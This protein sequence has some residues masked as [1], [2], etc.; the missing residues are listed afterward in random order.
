MMPL[1]V[2][3]SKGC[4]LSGQSK[5]YLESVLKKKGSSRKSQLVS[6]ALKKC[7]NLLKVNDKPYWF[8]SNE[9]FVAGYGQ[10]YQSTYLP[11][12]NWVYITK[13]SFSM[14]KN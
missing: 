1:L 11:T 7:E 4:N 13:H 5:I 6:L 3:L 8:F 9:I 10:G 14:I 12:N 2:W